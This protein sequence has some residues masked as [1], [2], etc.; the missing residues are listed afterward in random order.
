M[1]AVLLMDALSHFYINRKQMCPLKIT[2]KKRRLSSRWEWCVP[3]AVQQGASSPLT[4]WLQQQKEAF[5]G[6][7]CIC[8]SVCV[9][10]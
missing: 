8:V 3:P 6:L 2:I 9:G 1:D 7:D 5:L 10:H 4:S